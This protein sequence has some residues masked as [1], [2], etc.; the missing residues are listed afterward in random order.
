[1]GSAGDEAFEAFWRQQFPSIARASAG[2]V[3]NVED[4]A[5]VAQEA[6]ARAYQHWAR[7][8]RLDRP[9]AWVHRVAVHIAISRLR[10]LRRSGITAGPLVAEPPREPDDEL[11]RALRMLTPAQRAV[12]VL[13]FYVDLSVED[14]ARALRQR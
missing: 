14:V 2:I 11:L 7:V 10:R 3:G 1:M 4:G 12:V 9:D 6:F 8:S 5:E 13:R